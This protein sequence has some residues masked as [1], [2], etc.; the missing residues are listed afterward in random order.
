[1]HPPAAVVWAPAAPHR[2]PCALTRT[3]VPLLTHRP[4]SNSSWQVCKTRVCRSAHTTLLGTDKMQLSMLD[5]QL[6][7]LA[8]AVK[9]KDAAR[10]QT[11]LRESHAAKKEAMRKQELLLTGDPMDPEVQVCG[12]LIPGVFFLKAHT[13]ITRR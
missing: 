11:M 5:M 10:L 2:Q 8:A 7:A 6:P 12:Y 1:M 3:M 13:I 9:A 4:L